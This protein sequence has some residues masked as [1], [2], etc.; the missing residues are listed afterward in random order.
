MRIDLDDGDLKQGLLGLVL[1]LVEVVRDALRIQSLRRMEAGHLNDDEIERLG[2]A[3]MDLDVAI[4]KLKEEQGLRE[5]VRSVR[6]GLDDLVDQSLG[7]FRQQI[8][9]PVSRAGASSLPE[10]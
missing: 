7:G 6:D 4:E 2:K 1:A 8:G 5:V 9:A 10:G 3:L